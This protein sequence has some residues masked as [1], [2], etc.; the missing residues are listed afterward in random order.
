MNSGI[1]TD[2]A[3]AEGKGL[4]GT[5]KIKHLLR[6]YEKTKM[7]VT[8][9]V[10]AQFYELLK[11]VPET[12][13]NSLLE[14]AYGVSDMFKNGMTTPARVCLHPGTAKTPAAF[15]NL[16]LK[17]LTYS[18]Y[19]KTR[20]VFEYENDFSC[21]GVL[22]LE[23]TVRE[24]NIGRYASFLSAAN[25]E[26]DT[27]D[28]LEHIENTF[29][30]HKDFFA[31]HK[32]LGLGFQVSP[33]GHDSKH[34]FCDVLENY[35]SNMF[36]PSASLLNT[37]VHGS[38]F[39]INK[40]NFMYTDEAVKR[41]SSL[42]DGRVFSLDCEMVQTK[43]STSK[44][45]RVTIV[46]H[47]RSVVLD[48][49]IKFTE[50]ELEAVVD[51]RTQFSGI[52]REILLEK[53]VLSHSECLRKVFRTLFVDESRALT[54][55][56]EIDFCVV[57]NISDDLSICSALCTNS[58]A[59]ITSMTG[60]ERNCL[61]DAPVCSQLEGD[62][63]VYSFLDAFFLAIESSRDT[64]ACIRMPLLCGHGIDNDFR[65]LK[66]KYPLVIDTSMVSQ[67]EARKNKLRNLAK[68][69]LNRKI[70]ENGECGHDSAEDA[71]ATLDI[72]FANL[73]IARIPPHPV[74]RIS[75]SKAFY[76]K[77]RASEGDNITAN[78]EEKVALAEAS[79]V[80]S[81]FASVY[82]LHNE[83]TRQFYVDLAT[84]LNNTE[85]LTRESLSQ[86]LK[87]FSLKPGEN[88]SQVFIESEARSIK[89]VQ[90]IT[91]RHGCMPLPQFFSVLNADD[92]SLES[93]VKVLATMTIQQKTL[94]VA[95]IAEPG[96]EAAGHC[97]PE[98]KVQDYQPKSD[99]HDDFIVTVMKAL[100][101]ALPTNF[102][103]L[104]IVRNLELHTTYCYPFVV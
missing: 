30:T 83:T 80:G 8:Q 15:Q 62:I 52:T 60:T 31:E 68:R 27:A 35:T 56:D 24:R 5:K 7:Q 44:L 64:P 81:L 94:L 25:G 92:S 89:S 20:P 84:K 77:H 21:S 73:Y 4:P 102:V 67:F 57:D 65:S 38:L 95:S 9:K 76:Q 19:E 96:T 11:G 49:Y 87:Q 23:M 48:E 72:V 98:V 41:F 69:I 93:L 66:I 46:D 32:E 37:V 91:T 26:P 101:V 14:R 74:K 10:V 53:G 3:E 6:A 40:F 34:F 63:D 18:F 50:D 54:L 51:Y 17:M 99:M 42:W 47:S 58:E 104:F 13:V 86:R 36:S 29:L 45:A 97:E 59:D 71:L 88:V 12:S 39:K 75:K 61:S 28:A 16:I 90:D 103:A 70:Q 55:L 33:R 85:V 82:P 1:T 79:D 78:K 22:L 43:D 100:S 2:G